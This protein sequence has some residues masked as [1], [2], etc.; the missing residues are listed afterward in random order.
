MSVRRTGAVAAALLSLPLLAGLT[1]EAR[2]QAAVE[3][4]TANSDG[5]YTVPADWALKPT[6]L[7]AGATFRLLFVTSTT[8]NGVSADFAT[9]NTFVQDRAKA[10]HS[11]I[12]DSCGNKFKAIVST[13]STSQNARSN[14]AIRSTDTEIHWLNGPKA[15]DN[16][17]DFYDGSWDNRLVSDARTEAGTDGTPLALNNALQTQTKPFYALSPLF[18]VAAAQTAQA[19]VSTLGQTTGTGVW[20]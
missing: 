10:G 4:A 9:Y 5:S 20:T 12:S 19:F 16:Y 13:S 15:A 17:A 8:R 3:C 6:G 1:T 18:K 14:T 2:A 11:A 7:A